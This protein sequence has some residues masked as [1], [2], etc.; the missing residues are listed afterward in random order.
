[1]QTKANVENFDD[2]AMLVVKIISH[3]VQTM[4]DII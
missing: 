2:I 4:S 3:V 1:M